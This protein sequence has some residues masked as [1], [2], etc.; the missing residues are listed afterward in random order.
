MHS[1]LDG[2]RDPWWGM[3]GQ[4]VKRMRRR[5]VAISL[6][7]LAVALVLLVFVIG[8]P[9]VRAAS[10]TGHPEQLGSGEQLVSTLAAALAVITASVLISMVRSLR[11]TLRRRRLR[12]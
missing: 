8:A 7:I 3:D 4:G 11:R 2:A 12:A 5:R 9:S 10:L 1:P 6:G